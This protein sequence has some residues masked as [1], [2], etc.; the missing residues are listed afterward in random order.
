MAKAVV[1]KKKVHFISI[2]IKFEEETSKVLHLKYSFVQC[3]N[4]DTW[5]SRSAVSG[6]FWNV[7]LEK[8][9]NDQF[10]PSCKILRCLTKSQRG[11]E[12]PTDNK[13]KEG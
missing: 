13:K 11:E 2:G 7:V 8:D 1:N 6:K 10:G 4:L 5:E 3:S 12:N 9:G